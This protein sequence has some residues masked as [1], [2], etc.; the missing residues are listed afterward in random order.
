MTNKYPDISHHHPVSSWSKI[1]EKCPFIIS[2]ATEGT[3]FVDSTLSSFIKNCEAKKI[4]YWLY[5]YLRK[6]NELDQAKFLV[7]TCKDKVAGSKYFIGYILDVESGNS[8]SAV[9]EALKY[10]N[11]LGYKTMIYTMYADYNKYQYTIRS[12]GKDCA[13]WEARYGLNNGLYNSKYT[14]HSGVDLHQFTDQ[15]KC[16]GISDKIDL[17]RITGANGKKQDWFTTQL[18]TETKKKVYGIVATKSDPLRMRTKDTIISKVVRKIPR[19]A[20]VEIVQKG[21]NW[22]KVK[23]AGS[24]G[25]C[26]AKYIKIL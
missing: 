26:S 13:W 21:K 12:R 14:C 18:K 22:H 20:K 4:P 8:D 19:G 11:G 25:Y 23:Y 10:I 2:K 16:P 9:R 1:K 5:T 17:N 24:T 7:K 3:S 6:G 15:G